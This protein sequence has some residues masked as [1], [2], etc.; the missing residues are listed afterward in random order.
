MANAVDTTMVAK[1]QIFTFDTTQVG[2]NTLWYKV[3]AVG[4]TPATDQ[5]IADVADAFFGGSIKPLLN[6]NAEYR[7]IRVQMYLAIAPIPLFVDVVSTNS[8]GVGTGGPTSLPKQSS[9]IISWYT[10]LPRQANRGRSYI[11]FPAAE[12]DS[13]D[14][15]P[16][17]PYVTA[18]NAL[19]GQIRAFN[20]TTTGG[21]TCSLQQVLFKRFT[22]T[23]EPVV[24]GL[25]R[26]LWATQ[27]RRGS[28][29]RPTGVPPF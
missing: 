2:I 13:G 29:G 26:P 8:A 21:R 17:A 12:H 15:F 3:T 18:L 10:N 23:F 4:G 20:G 27:R 25:A 1:V 16:D 5:D 7:G 24:I 19:R 9:G 6:N 28:Y 14:G 11:P 22:K